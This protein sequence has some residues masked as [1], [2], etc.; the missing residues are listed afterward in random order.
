MQTEISLR[1]SYLRPLS[2]AKC[3][4]AMLGLLG[5]FFAGRGLAGEPGAGPSVRIKA[6]T[7]VVYGD[8]NEP[9][10]RVDLYFPAAAESSESKLPVVLMI[11]GGAWTAGDKTYDR[12]HARKLASR[13]YF[14]AVINYRLAPAHKFPA[15]LDDC[16]LALSWIQ[17]Q[18]A[19]R[20][21]DL[22]RV[23]AW[24]YSAGGHLTALLALMTGPE[25]AELPRLRACVCG[26]TPFDLT[27]LPGDTSVLAGVFG[28]KPAEAPEVYRNASPVSH[29]Q[30]IAPPMFVFHGGKDWLVPNKNALK[31]CELLKENDIEHA[32]CEVD[33]K[34]HLATFVDL[35]VAEKSFDFLDKILKPDSAWRTAENQSK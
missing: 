15:Q 31:M 2:Y 32:Y 11:H 20:N 9:M 28:A 25:S 5:I 6:E 14:V 16:R 12:I 17:G 26:G 22:E 7:N 24:G 10:H 1:P 4:A 18:A 27:N 3:L 29:V 21:L 13:G 19:T 33:G 23:A 30:R 34:G 35:N 8:E